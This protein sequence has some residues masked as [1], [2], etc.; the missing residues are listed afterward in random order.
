MAKGTVSM[1][2]TFQHILDSDAILLRVLLAAGAFTFA[3]GLFF[4]DTLSGPYRQMMHYAP[5]WVWGCIFLAYAFVK[6][7]LAE[8]PVPAFVVYVVTTLGS[9]LWFAVF[10]SFAN[11]PE[12]QVGAADMM[13]LV[14]VLCEVWVAATAIAK[15]R[16]NG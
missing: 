3:M 12:R 16:T 6:L 4:A 2:K 1:N 8:Y 15:G 5:A 11:N 9:S 13:M 7:A 10:L 14:C